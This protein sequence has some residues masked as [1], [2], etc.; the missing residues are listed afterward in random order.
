MNFPNQKN[1][2][3][4]KTII[5]NSI[6]HLINNDYVLLEIPNHHNIGDSLIWQG[7]LE[8]L[9][10]VP[11]NLAYSCNAYT[12]NAEKI[13][14]DSVILL[15]G[16]GSFGDFWPVSQGFRSNIIKTH[17]KQRIIIFP[18]TVY[19][20]NLDNLKRDAQLY[21][22]HPDLIICARDI[23]SQELLTEYFFNCKILL[24]PDMAF[25]LDFSKY[26][27]IDKTKKTLIMKRLDKE[28]GDENLI[29]EV[30]CKLNKNGEKVEAKDWPGF[31]PQGS[32][33]G[34]I[35][36]Y[37]FTGEIK[38]SKL[39]FNKPFLN[40]FVNDVYGLKPRN[41]RETLIKKGI[42]FINEYD[43]VYSTRLHGFILAV[44]LNKKASFFDNSYGKNS[45]FFNTWMTD[46]E[47]VHLL[48]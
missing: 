26:H 29:E 16:G 15:H 42:D 2:E 46:F 13:P 25:Y 40:L 45:N 28:L 6:F 9:K 22:S 41:N 20:T 10:T 44:L 18:Q 38:L 27:K 24:V 48:K 4:L 11:Y 31:Y 35:Q 17:K 23:K 8:F 3:K 32:L 30:I 5:I 7:E 12:L 43:E 21:N 36:A 33:K 14:K 39:F 19:Y 37:L 47:N 34:R 1:I